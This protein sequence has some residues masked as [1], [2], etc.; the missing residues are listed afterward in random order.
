M[1]HTVKRGRGS[2]WKEV[3]SHANV[4]KNVQIREPFAKLSKKEMVVG[5]MKITTTTRVEKMSFEEVQ[6]M[7]EDEI[8]ELCR[9]MRVMSVSRC[10]RLVYDLKYA[11]QYPASKGMRQCKYRAGKKGLYWI[12]SF[13]KYV[14]NIHAKEYDNATEDQDFDKIR[15]LKFV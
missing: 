10:E 5:N 9:E 8:G 6:G 12:A 3:M 7:E 4:N 13:G 1:R 2:V 11:N 14:C 15:S